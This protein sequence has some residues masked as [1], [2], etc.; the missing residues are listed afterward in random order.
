MSGKEGWL[1]LAK[2]ANRMKKITH[3]YECALAMYGFEE[4]NL[5]ME[6]L[7]VSGRGRIRMMQHK[8]STPKKTPS[9]NQPSPIFVSRQKYEI[10]PFFAKY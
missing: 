10:S 3:T 5:S 7:T 4:R 1:L 2:R 9:A 8:A 6:R